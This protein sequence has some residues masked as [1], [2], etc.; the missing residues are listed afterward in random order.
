METYPVDIDP[1]QVV[2][3]VKAE[4]ETSPSTCKI[5]ARR[6][7]E[8]RDIPIRSELHLGDEEREDLSEIATIATL[9]IAPMHASEGW[10][11]RVVV[12]DE[13]GPRITEGGMTSEGEQ[14][15]DLGTFYHEFIRPVRGSASIV[16]EVEGPEARAH[17]T[18]LL[19]T[20]EKNRH[21]SEHDPAKRPGGKVRRQR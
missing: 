14:Q 21:S 20:I 13:I 16:V 15:I 3:W 12:E 17:V 1:T 10:L 5:V 11:L 7:R 4:S 9:E 19:G 18:R 2:R 8:V 6:S